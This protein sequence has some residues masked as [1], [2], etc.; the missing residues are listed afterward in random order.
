MAHSSRYQIVID[1]IRF[2][3]HHPGRERVG[4]R[5]WGRERGEGGGEEKRVRDRVREGSESKSGSFNEQ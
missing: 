5:E 3:I 1:V 4:E 2:T